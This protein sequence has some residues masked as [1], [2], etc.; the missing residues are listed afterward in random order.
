[1]ANPFQYPDNGT[2]VFFV[3]NYL[4]RNCG[5]ATFQHRGPIRHPDLW[6]SQSKQG[7]W[8]SSRC[9]PRTGKKYPKS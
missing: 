9:P 5:I 3:E 1:M 2:K 8:V 4:P 6:P 7:D